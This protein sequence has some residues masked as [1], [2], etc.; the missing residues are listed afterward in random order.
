MNELR[1][2]LLSWFKSSYQGVY[3]EDKVYVMKYRPS[4]GSVPSLPIVLSSVSGV[5]S[6][7]SRRH[8]VQDDLESFLVLTT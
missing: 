5:R 2:C 3:V 1:I 7:G 4:M 8:E 6:P